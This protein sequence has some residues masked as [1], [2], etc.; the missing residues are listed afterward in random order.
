MEDGWRAVSESGSVGG[1]KKKE[2]VERQLNQVTY[3]WR[4]GA[5]LKDVGG[6][7]EAKSNL[8]TPF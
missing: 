5:D 1:R 2:E 8:F 7:V 3:V 6:V 4:C